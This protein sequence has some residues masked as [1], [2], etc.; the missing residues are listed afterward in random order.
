MWSEQASFAPINVVRQVGLHARW[1]FEA[2]RVVL[3]EPRELECVHQTVGV[4]LHHIRERLLEH[5]QLDRGPLLAIRPLLEE[6]HEAVRVRRE[7]GRE[8]SERRAAAER[9]RERS[10]SSIARLG[11]LEENGTRAATGVLLEKLQHE[12]EDLRE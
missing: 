9:E 3:G 11:L 7:K 8:R 10:V 1:E 5:D 2:G 6:A 4:P 12:L